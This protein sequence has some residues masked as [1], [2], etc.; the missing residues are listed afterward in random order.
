MSTRP[1]EAWLFGAH[2]YFALTRVL[3]AEDD[4]ERAEAMV[5]P[6]LEA[7]ERFRWLENVAYGA[8]LAGTAQMARG[9][10]DAARERLQQAL[11]VASEAGFAGAEWEAHAALAALD[12][13]QGGDDARPCCERGRAGGTTGR[14]TRRRPAGGD[15]QATGARAV[16]NSR[17]A[18]LT[19]TGQR[20]SRPVAGALEGQ[21]LA[22]RV[23]RHCGAPLPWRHVVVAA[24]D[25]EDGL[26]EV[27]AVALSTCP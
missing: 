24:L 3:L 11:T 21:Q 7:A 4:P 18:R 5:V 9:R 12:R 19:S 27:A 14:G 23:A 26:V 25:H 20:P 10:T 16:T 1:G 8:L 17:I 13:E 22:A 2:A 15:V 6:V